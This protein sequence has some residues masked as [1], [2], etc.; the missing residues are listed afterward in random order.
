MLSFMKDTF[1]QNIIKFITMNNIS[2]HQFAYPIK[3]SLSKVISTTWISEACGDTTRRKCGK[4]LS[5]SMIKYTLVIPPSNT[6]FIVGKDSFSKRTSSSNEART[7][8]TIY[9]YNLSCFNQDIIK[10]EAP[11]HLG[12]FSALDW[13]IVFFAGS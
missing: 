1:Q 11:L 13:Y 2:S 8:D 6:L 7:Q 9:N 12:S 5:L 4:I 10:Y 3:Q